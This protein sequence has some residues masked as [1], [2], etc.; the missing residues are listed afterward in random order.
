MKA[1][2]LRRVP[3]CDLEVSAL[4]MGCSTIGSLYRASSDEEARATMQTGWELGLRYFDVA[5]FYGYTLAE[6]R[7]G[8]ALQRWGNGHLSCISAGWR[9]PLVGIDS[10]APA[11]YGSQIRAAARANAQAAADNHRR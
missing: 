5:P 3:R 6:H 7:V 8:M 2:H 9:A 4:G 10:A 1:S 11:A